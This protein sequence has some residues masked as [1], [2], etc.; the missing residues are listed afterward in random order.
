MISRWC[1]REVG[2]SVTSTRSTYGK[3]AV[4]YCQAD[5]AAASYHHIRKT[6]DSGGFLGGNPESTAHEEVVKAMK[7]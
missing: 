2:K 4:A 6:V 1:G 3:F 7:V 5:N